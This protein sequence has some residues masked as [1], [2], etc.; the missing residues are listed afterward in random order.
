VVLVD[1]GAFGSFGFGG[2]PAIVMSAG[3]DF[4]VLLV[5]GVL[6]TDDNKPLPDIELPGTELLFQGKKCLNLLGD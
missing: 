4:I 6:V 1:F 5:L 2:F 3:H